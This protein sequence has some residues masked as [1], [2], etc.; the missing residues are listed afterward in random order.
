MAAAAAS[1]DGFVSVNDEWTGVNLHHEYKGATGT[2]TRAGNGW[3]IHYDFTGG[4]YGFVQVGHDNRKRKT[5]CA[6]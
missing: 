3:K 2:V 4:G 5:V 6:R 1:S